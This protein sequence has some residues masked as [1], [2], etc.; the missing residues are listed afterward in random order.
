MKKIIVYSHPDCLL[1]HNGT[2]H[3]E[4]KERLD[5]ILNSFKKN[6]DIVFQFKEAPL[7]NLLD[8]SLVHPK[9]YM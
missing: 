7:A 5:I 1:K 6:K 3:P 8:V 9:E 2:N 4:R